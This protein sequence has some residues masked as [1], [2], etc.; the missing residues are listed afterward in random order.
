MYMC[1]APVIGDNLYHFSTT[2][3]LIWYYVELY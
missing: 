2:S 1:L 3:M